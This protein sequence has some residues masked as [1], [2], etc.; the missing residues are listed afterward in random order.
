MSD[1]PT[2]TETKKEEASIE[3][4]PS[5]RKKE[6]FGSE[7]LM[8]EEPAAFEKSKPVSSD[9]VSDLLGLE[10]NGADGIEDLRP[11]DPP[12]APAASFSSQNSETRKSS[13]FGDD[14]ND[15][16][17]SLHS[18]EV[19]HSNTALPS[20]DASRNGAKKSL[21][22]DEFGVQS[23]LYDS[24]T[25]S[26]SSRTAPAK[27]VHQQID[28]LNDDSAVP[29]TRAAVFSDVLT[30]W[31]DDV[32]LMP[33]SMPSSSNAN[34]SEKTETVAEVEPQAEDEV[35][36]AGDTC[37][38][39]N[40]APA[41]DSEV[42]SNESTA[43]PSGAPPEDPS[44]IKSDVDDAPSK[45][46][47]LDDDAARRMAALDEIDA[48]MRKAF[49][50][51]RAAIVRTKQAAAAQA[52][53]QAAGIAKMKTLKE[54]EARVKA[55]AEASEAQSEEVKEK[56]A[57]LQKLES[58]RKKLE[59]DVKQETKEKLEKLLPELQ[60]AEAESLEATKR[61]EII[62]LA[63][64]ASEMRLQEAQER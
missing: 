55:D 57:K 15:D 2:P 3:S 62:N 56:T 58:I 21:F 29:D 12:A 13:L 37:E 30:P 8:I 40:P 23:N 38:I 39:S 42:M 59:A 63:K 35:P 16:I 27:D 11:K 5:S 47:E 46:S 49:E 6:L 17:A 7:S 22:G 45:Y 50:D 64:F 4:M 53:V 60:K 61:A 34:N 18:I 54:M 36:V 32:L 44:D 1:I 31:D 20:S 41:D 26:A 52:Q 28:L 33:S 24:K 14:D 25:S 43:S 51:K 19:V 10:S 48:E 9:Y